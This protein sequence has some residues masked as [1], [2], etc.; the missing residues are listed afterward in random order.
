MDDYPNDPEFIHTLLL[1]YGVTLAVTLIFAL[2]VYVIMAIA[3]SRFFGKV[4]VERWKAWIPV[5]NN[6]TWLQVG[7]FPGWLALLVLVPGGSIVT[8]IFLYIGMYRSGLAFGKQGSFVVLGVFLPF[9]WAFI[10][11]GHREVYEP[12]RIRQAGYPAPLIGHGAEARQPGAP[13]F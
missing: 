8:S 3:L 13:I 11:S 6:W 12:A 1:I 2:V 4:G 5:Y 7:G 9:V 10:L